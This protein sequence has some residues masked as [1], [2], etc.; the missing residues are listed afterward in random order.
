MSRALM[1]ITLILAALLAMPL[2]LVAEDGGVF[3]AITKEVRTVQATSQ[4]RMDQYNSSAMT[5]YAYLLGNTGA[6]YI[7][8]S[9]SLAIFSVDLALVQPGELGSVSW[10][11][12]PRPLLSQLRAAVV[13]GR[14]IEARVTS[15]DYVLGSNCLYFWEQIKRGRQT[16]YRLL[17]IIPL[18]RKSNDV[19]RNEF[20]QFGVEECEIPVA[21]RDDVNMGAWIQRVNA[22]SRPVKSG[23]VLNMLQQ[24]E[25]EQSTASVMDQVNAAL[26]NMKQQ[27]IDSR[28]TSR[29]IL[30]IKAGRAG[31]LHVIDKNGT[32]D[33]KYPF[34]VG[35]SQYEISIE[36]GDV[37]TYYIEGKHEAP[38]TTTKAEVEEVVQ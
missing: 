27:L 36:G 11:L 18:G 12:S 8:A 25:Q 2:E 20:V 13:T 7:V 26:Q 34:E 33:Q 9:G 38:Q 31:V 37:L 14:G 19:C 32:N 4:I 21:E 16:I 3:A 35:I 1:A 15:V 23:E 28:K 6:A 5:P 24:M 10:S 30:T 17:N 29:H 22:G